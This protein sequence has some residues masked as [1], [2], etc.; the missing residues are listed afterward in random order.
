MSCSGLGCVL[1]DGAVT[2]GGCEG[3]CVCVIVCGG[4]YVLG[5]QSINPGAYIV[6]QSGVGVP[7]EVERLAWGSG[8]GTQLAWEMRHDLP[9]AETSMGVEQR[10]LG[11]GQ[12]GLFL[13][14]TSVAVLFL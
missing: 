5:E 8:L 10:P 6:D 13:L 1:Y 3:V 7:E 14:F 9:T 4:G 2:S 12:G 11:T